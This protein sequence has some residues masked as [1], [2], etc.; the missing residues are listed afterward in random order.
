MKLRNVAVVRLKVVVVRL[1][2]AIRRKLL[3]VKRRLMCVSL[4]GGWKLRS[5]LPVL[6]VQSKPFSFTFFLP[7]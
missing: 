7:S 4:R 2:V 6:L 5:A 1:K 3:S